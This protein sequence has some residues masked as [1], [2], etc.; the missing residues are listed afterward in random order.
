MYLN[1]VIYLSW[2]GSVCGD[3]WGLV[4]VF[5]FC[6]LVLLFCLFSLFTLL[7]LLLGFFFLNSSK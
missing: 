5:L 3:L 7:I 2:V 1:D 6:F 4:G